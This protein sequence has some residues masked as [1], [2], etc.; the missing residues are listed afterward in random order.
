MI[1]NK[2]ISY[3][4]SVKIKNYIDSTKLRNEYAPSYWKDRD[5]W[6]KLDCYCKWGSCLMMFDEIQQPGMRVVD[7]GVG[8]G[9]VPH[10]ISNQG[11][12]VS[13][14]DNMRIDHPFK[15]SLVQ[16]V[17]RDAKE[18]LTDLDEESVDV[19]IDS[20]SVTHFE[21]DGTS[22]IGW[23]KVLSAS[24]S[25]LKSGGY[26]IISSDSHLIEQNKR[27]GEFL[28]PKEIVSI[29]KN[30]GFDLPKEYV[31]DIGDSIKRTE[32]G[33]TDLSVANFMFLKK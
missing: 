13:G 17:L 18:F 14:V 8:E 5:L 9:P 10:V 21:F 19:F 22:N 24:Y 11:H 27:T 33:E 28:I 31:Y 15:T 6:D 7:L 2:I 25:K 3:E 1:S 12:D 29:A 23:E 16:M 30:V 4:D 32:G 26:F 20:C